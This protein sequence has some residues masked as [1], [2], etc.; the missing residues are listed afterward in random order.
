MTSILSLSDTTQSR[1]SRKSRNGDCQSSCAISDTTPVADFLA[2][3]ILKA[4]ERLFIRDFEI[5]VELGLLLDRF[6][7]S[8]WFFLTRI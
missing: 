5:I 4:E 1:V 2:D 6:V 8:R 3:V 7:S